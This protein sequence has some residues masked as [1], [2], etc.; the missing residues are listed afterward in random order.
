MEMEM[1]YWNGNSTEHIHE[2]EIRFV[3][4]GHV[5]CGKDVLMILFVNNDYTIG[6]ITLLCNNIVYQENLFSVI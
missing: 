2:E 3:L 1:E 5:D 4:T 6:V